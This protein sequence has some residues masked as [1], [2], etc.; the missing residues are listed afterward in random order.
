MLDP[1]EGLVEEVVEAETTDLPTDSLVVKLSNVEKDLSYLTPATQYMINE[2][3]ADLLGNRSK[4][5]NFALGERASQ[6]IAQSLVKPIKLNRE[7]LDKAF[8][9][10]TTE[11]EPFS[12][13]NELG[14]EVSRNRSD[15][16]PAAMEAVAEYPAPTFTTPE[17][18][19]RGRKLGSK[20]KPK[21]LEETSFPYE[22]PIPFT[23][24]VIEDIPLNP[25]P[26]DIVPIKKRGRKSK[27]LGENI[28]IPATPFQL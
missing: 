19:G 24:E 27:S 25:T 13:T 1:T 12:F 17:R 3:A 21:S 7:F 10:A 5:D 9:E 18:V 26:F 15:K 2:M 23:R 22:E 20:N 14:R 16:K 4:M 28:I 6:S 11:L 8:S